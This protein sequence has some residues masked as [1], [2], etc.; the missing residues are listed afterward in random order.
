MEAPPTQLRQF[1]VLTSPQLLHAEIA[2][3]RT[4]VINLLA[5]IYEQNRRLAVLEERVGVRCT[6]ANETIDDHG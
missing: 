1:D 2:A 5:T 3:L 6:H 4:D